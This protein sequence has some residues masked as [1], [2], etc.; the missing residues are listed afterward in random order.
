MNTYAKF[1]REAKSMAG[2][3]IHRAKIKKAITSYE[4]QVDGMKKQQF[5]DWNAA[6]EVA[7]GIKNEVLANLPEMLQEFEEKLTSRGATVLW[8]ENA[9]QARHYIEEIISRHNA[10]KVVKSKSMTTE[11]IELNEY[12]ESRGIENWESDLGELIVQLADEK[13]YHIV[14]PAMHKSKQEIARLFVE[15]LGIEYTENAEEL[16]MAARAHLR[17]AFVTADIGITGANFIIAEEGAIVMTENEG[18][19]RLGMACPKVHIAIAGIEKMLPRLAD[20]SLF[21]P[22]L[23]TSGTGQQLTG[24]NSIVRGP[25]S[26]AEPDG[27]EEMIVILLDNGRSNIYAQ[28]HFREVLRC[29]RCGAC[30]NACPVFR[31]VGGHT[32][33]TTYQGPVGSIITPQLRG[34]A[35]WQHLAHACSLCGACTEVCPVGIDLHPL[36]L[37]T[38]WQADKEH[39]ASKKWQFAIKMWSKIIPS[40]K[41]IDTFRPLMKI[42]L[43]L[44]KPFLSANQ[45]KRIPTMA[46][47]SF[48]QMWENNESTR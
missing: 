32:Y 35:A 36:L 38:R 31:S 16:T 13:P 47:K 41:V 23:T 3:E 17:R 2:N 12:L 43:P 40:R 30:L 18:N 14:T 33:A 42:F 21:L 46:K 4:I 25:K 9:E 5:Q 28:D 22:L 8:A 45:K 10:R 19:G 1:M 27:P 24:Y 44:A 26:A 11:E 34:M 6:R 15:K 29:I 39:A 37:E 7:A 48:A 20:L